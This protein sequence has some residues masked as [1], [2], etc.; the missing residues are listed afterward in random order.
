MAKMK[1]E[2]SEKPDGKYLKF[3]P[4]CGSID[5]AFDKMQAQNYFL[6]HVDYACNKCGSKFKTPFEGTVEF[7]KEFREKLKKPNKKRKVKK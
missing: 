1:N 4:F 7:I 6:M 5:L 3:C 2:K